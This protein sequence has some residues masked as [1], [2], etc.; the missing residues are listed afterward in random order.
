MKENIDHLKELGIKIFTTIFTLSTLLLLIFQNS[1]SRDAILN[2]L[3]LSIFSTSLFIVLL[4][5]Y[6]WKK[7][8]LFASRYELLWCLFEKYEVPILKKKY[9]CLIKYEWPEGSPGEKKASIEVKQ[10]YTSINITLI[11]DEIRSDSIVSEIV[12]QDNIFTLF[13]IYKT[14][15]K[16][17]FHKNNP[18]QFGGC[19]IT[20]DSIT[21]NVSNDKLHGKYWTTSKTIGDIELY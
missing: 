16:A 2:I 17:I 3:S 1:I 13:Y 6:L 19:K 21:D 20:L 9:E 4:D 8:L 5:K 11:T 10:T 18:P 7:L 15:P 14:N 12:K